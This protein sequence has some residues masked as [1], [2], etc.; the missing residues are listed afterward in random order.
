[1][2]YTQV[3][4]KAT[5]TIDANMYPDVEALCVSI[6][7]YLGNNPDE[8][9][10]GHLS[11]LG[12]MDTDE[13]VA[14]FVSYL[15]L[16]GDELTIDLDTEEDHNY[17][18][19]VFD[20]LVNHIAYLQTSEQM[21]VHYTTIDSRDGVDSSVSYYDQG[22]QYIS[23]EDLKNNKILSVREQIQEDFCSYASAID[24]E[25]IFFTQ[26]VLDQMCQ[27][28]VDNFKNLVDKKDT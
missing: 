1:M 26:E 11:H 3:V 7:D 22:G 15:S 13:L 28:V 2:S 18:S 9:E 21:E 16:D 14:E 23:A 10:T 19:S 27:I 6:V 4:A 25:G 17:D 8:L 5:C 20:F 12:E 24:D